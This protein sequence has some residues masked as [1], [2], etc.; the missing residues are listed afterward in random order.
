VEPLEHWPLVGVL[1][2]APGGFDVLDIDPE[3]LGWFD[4]QH[5][6]L[7]RTHQ[8]RR[9]GLH[10]WF[11]HAL[12]LR[13]SEGKI[14]PGVDV[15]ADGAMAIWWPREGL[16]VCDAPVA[17]WPEW[18]LEKAR[19]K[20]YRKGV[21]P[22][23]SVVHGVAVVPGAL[24]ALV[25][26]DPCRYRDH[27]EWLVLMMSAHAAGIDRDAFIEWSVGDPI[28]ADH[29]DEI[30]RRWDSLNVEGNANGRVTAKKLLAEAMIERV[31]PTY[32]HAH[33]DQHKWRSPLALA[34]VATR[35]L[36]H[37]T[38]ALLRELSS[39]KGERRDELLFWVAERF[40]EI[41]GEGK[42]KPEI[43]V[44]LLEG[45]C[46]TNRLWIGDQE[47]CKRTIARAFVTIEEKEWR[48]T[49]MTEPTT[50]HERA[51]NE[52]DESGGRYSRVNAKPTI[53]GTTPTPS[54][55][56]GPA[57]SG[58]D[59]G[60]EPPLDYNINDQPCVGE[61]HELREVNHLPPEGDGSAAPAG[62]DPSPPPAAEPRPSTTIRRRL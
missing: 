14:A 9:G 7:T 26:L 2:G 51:Q 60:I 53:T 40:R 22:L 37:R 45:A 8:T 21:P 32:P 34:P 46:R 27:D 11:R 50:Y 3:G 54:Y 62:G 33:H 13:K 44:H 35:N 29:G 4:G 5:L 58:Q 49:V 57:W 23:S 48:K 25:M 24:S 10:L 31:W 41:I 17:E 43:A 15:R 28:Y 38:K 61:P 1:T 20:G 16:P 18:L 47:R 39:A 6:P 56:A 55:P 36:R 12:G 52:I 19:A 30:A 42:L 59:G